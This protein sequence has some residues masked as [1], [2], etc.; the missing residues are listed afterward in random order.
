MSHSFAKIA[1]LAASGILAGC[2]ASAQG[3]KRD[4]LGVSPGQTFSEAQASARPLPADATEFSVITASALDPIVVKSVKLNLCTS[5]DA[6][7]VTA[8]INKSYHLSLV[9]FGPATASS[10]S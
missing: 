4:I 10:V 6:A 9:P 7:T 2:V 1:L 5:E 3:V 8:K